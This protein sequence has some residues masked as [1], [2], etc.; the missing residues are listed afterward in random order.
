MYIQA[1]EGHCLGENSILVLEGLN[2]RHAV[3]RGICVSILKLFLPS[4]VTE[5]LN[6]LGWSHDLPDAYRLLSCSPTFDYASPGGFQTMYSCL[7]SGKNI[8]GVFCIDYHVSFSL[9]SNRPTFRV[10]IQFVPHTEHRGS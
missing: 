8:A 7:I 9:N 3:Q 2:E 10:S 5:T 6:R 1:L 4:E